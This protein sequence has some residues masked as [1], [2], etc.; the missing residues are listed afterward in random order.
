[1]TKELMLEVARPLLCTATKTAERVRVKGVDVTCEEDIPA[2]VERCWHDC[3]SDLDVEV[4]GVDANQLIQD[5]Q[6][7][8]AS[9]QGNVL[10]LVTRQ[11]FR[12]DIICYGAAAEL[13]NADAFW[14]I[15]VQALGKLLRR[16]YLIAAHLSH[17]LLMDALVEQMAQRDEE[18][19]TNY[20]RYG[21]S[22]A[23]RYLQTDD[24]AYAD[25]MVGDPTYAHIARQLVRA[26]LCHNGSENYFAIW[27]G[28]LKEMES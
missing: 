25:L 13:E 20:H 15:A 17:M 27:R 23:L 21:H 16:D 9:V 6:L 18:Y 7:L 22:E 24:A 11:G 3:L 5:M 2:A 19:H 8:G 10:R 28:Y 1:M 12:A 4:W 14:F 26:A